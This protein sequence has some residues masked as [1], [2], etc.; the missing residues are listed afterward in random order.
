VFACAG[1][2]GTIKRVMLW[3]YSLDET[4]VRR[5]AALGWYYLE[6]QHLTKLTTTEM[7]SLQTGLRFEGASH[8]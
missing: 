4:Q 3:R 8:F 7:V 1:Y 5:L 2:L 6:P